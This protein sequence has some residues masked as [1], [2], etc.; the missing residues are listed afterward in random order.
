MKL[1]LTLL[2]TL[3]LARLRAAEPDW[4]LEGTA[5]WQARDSQAEWVFKGQMWIGGG[6]FRSDEAPPR[7][8]SPRHALIENA[9][10]VGSLL[11]RVKARK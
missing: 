6:W 10:G 3:L 9:A 7:A 2:T 5:A 11:T 8:S 1:V 4:I